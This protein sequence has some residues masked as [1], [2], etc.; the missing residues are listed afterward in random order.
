MDDH[1]DFAT[2]Y[3]DSPLAPRMAATLWVTALLAYDAFRDDVPEM[4]LEDLPRVAQSFADEQFIAALGSRFDRIAV[5]LASGSTDPADLTTC[6]ADELALLLVINFARETHADGPMGNDWI[7]DLPRRP[8]D[9]D[10]GWL[11]DILF[12]DLDVEVLF[13]PA[14]DGAE[15]PQWELYQREGYANLHPRDWFKPFDTATPAD[16]LDPTRCQTAGGLLDGLAER[17]RTKFGL[18]S[19]RQFGLLQTQSVDLTRR[20]PTERTTPRTCRP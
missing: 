5:R 8:K 19:R 6:I 4:W 17:I 13:N 14:L 3:A 2:L 20:G 10:Y 18:G 9:E 15:D 11:T 12:E 1:P 7:D 16:W